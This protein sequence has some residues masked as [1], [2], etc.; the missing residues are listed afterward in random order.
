MSKGRSFNYFGSMPKM[1]SATGCISKISRTDGLELLLLYN[2]TGGSF[3]TL[4]LI[5]KSL[6]NSK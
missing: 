2:G 5:Q 1:F 6:V 3:K 4:V